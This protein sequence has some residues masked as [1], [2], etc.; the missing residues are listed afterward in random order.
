M[1]LD[2]LCYPLSV[3]SNEQNRHESHQDFFFYNSQSKRAYMFTK[4]PPKNK[5]KNKF[6]AFA[7]QDC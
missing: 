5:N 3:Y 1:Y 7:I 2:L 6:R 4:K